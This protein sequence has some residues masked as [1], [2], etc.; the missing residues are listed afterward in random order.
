M[1]YGKNK[2]LSKGKKGG[3]KKQLDPFVRKNWYDVKCP[4]YLNSASR[5]AGRTVVTKTTGQRIETEGLK[6]RVAEFNLADLAT[7]NEDSHKKVRLEIQD[8]TGRACLTDFHGLGLTRDKMHHMIRKRHS[9]IE[10]RADVK[11]TDQYVVRLFVIAFTKEIKESQVKVF[12]YAQSAQIKKIRTKICA[13]LQSTVSA[14]SLK[15]LVNLLVSD[16]LE[17]DIKSA[18]QCVYPLDPVHVFKVKLIRKPKVDFTKLMEIH[19]TTGADEGIAVEE[20][21]EAENLIT[22]QKA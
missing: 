17:S 13:L 15:D 21:E 6:G 16:K 12:S 2:K 8:I 4:T 20:V 9:L 7:K 1:A 14:G 22:A 3:K 18:C 5:R 11:T 10:A 19:D